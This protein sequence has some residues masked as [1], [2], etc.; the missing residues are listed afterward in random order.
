MKKRSDKNSKTSA[1]LGFANAVDDS[2]LPP[3]GVELPSEKEQLICNQFNRACAKE[4]WC[5]TD[6]ILLAKIVKM[7]ADILTAQVG[8]DEVGMIVQNKRGMQNPNLLISVIDALER[9]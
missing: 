6:L 2:I 5:D 3:A 8:L 7:E 4:N 9:R 1:V